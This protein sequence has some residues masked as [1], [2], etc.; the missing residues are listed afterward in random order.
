M[1]WLGGKGVR[2]EHFL[3][4]ACDGVTLSHIAKID[5]LDEI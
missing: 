1:Y 2:P 5:G 3:R 4:G